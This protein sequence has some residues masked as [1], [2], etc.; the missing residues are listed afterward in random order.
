MRPIE[1]KY[2]YRQF[3]HPR[4]WGTWLTISVMYLISLLP[5]KGKLWLGEKLG[6]LLLRLGGSRRHTAQTNIRACFPDWSDAEQQKLLRETFISNAT[7]YIENTIAWWNDLQPFYDKLEVE[8]KEHF[9]E[10]V[11]RGK[12][13]LVIGAHFSIM[14]FALPLFN[15]ISTFN[16]MYRP[17][18]NKLLDAF[19]ERRRRR[20]SGAHFNKRQTRDMVEFIKQGN[21]VWY[22][23]DQ[24][25]GNKHCVFAPLMGV[26][27][28]CLTTP[29]WIARE[30]GA[31]VIQLSQF[32]DTERP[33][34]YRLVFTEILEDYPC[35]DEVANATTLNQGLE[36][37]IRRDPAQYL[38]L[39]RRFKTRPE[40]EAKFY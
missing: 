19:L 11:R 22:G 10:A 15:Y 6:L 3:L 18:N 24:D 8:G 28:A 4:Y 25:L 21:V 38:W 33:G 26:Q 36:R 5:Y 32:R 2:Y 1:P 35:D 13:V 12:G 31:T 27:T 14:D 7:G 20:N 9:D 39:H 30:T 29:A 17:Q 37:A 40:G 23:P 16:Y 34:V